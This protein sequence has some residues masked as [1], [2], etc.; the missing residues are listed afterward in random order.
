MLVLHTP[1]RRG[2]PAVFVVHTG[3]NYGCRALGHFFFNQYM[4]FIMEGTFSGGFGIKMSAGGGVPKSHTFETKTLQKK[5][6]L[7]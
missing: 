1:R 2:G 6:F 7:L 4:D 5:A 3:A